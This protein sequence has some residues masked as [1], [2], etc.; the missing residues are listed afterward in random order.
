MDA[1]HPDI[2]RLLADADWVRAVARRLIDDPSVADDVAQ[3][4]WLA[5]L[6]R[7][8]AR[9]ATP[10]AW[11]RVVVLNALRQLRRGEARRRERE[12][13]R[14]RPRDEVAPSTLEVVE[15]FSTQHAVASAVLALDEP[16][17]ETLLLRF[18]EDLSVR[19]IAERTGVPATTVQSRVSRGLAKAAARAGP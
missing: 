6:R 5:A 9:D 12:Q 2:E 16:Y 3:D 10:R 13:R 11:M 17:R 4:A 1:A 18:Y 8:P 14:V 19:A 7:P 15:R